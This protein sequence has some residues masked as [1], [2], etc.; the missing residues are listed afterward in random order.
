ME[1]H[2]TSYS[3]IKDHP[4]MTYLST[5]QH[6][7]LSQLNCT[8][9]NPPSIGPWR[10]RYFIEKEPIVLPE[11][12]LT[13]HGVNEEVTVD[14]KGAKEQLVRKFNISVNCMINLV[15]VLQWYIL[16]VKGKKDWFIITPEPASKP[17]P[18]LASKGDNVILQL[19][20]PPDEWYFQYVPIDL[21]GGNV[22]ELA[23][24]FDFAFRRTDLFR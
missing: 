15:T 6:F 19:V 12:F 8:N 21:A 9:M 7:N 24:L 2:L 1:A 5:S 17:P 3:S 16:P 18:A 23:F 22:Y 20:P 13:G 14:K 11:L 4:K 10:F